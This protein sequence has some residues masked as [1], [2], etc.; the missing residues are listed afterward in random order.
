[1]LL[2]TV[3]QFQH[4]EVKDNYQHGQ[5]GGCLVISRLPLKNTHT[6]ANIL[7]SKIETLKLWKDSSAKFESV[8]KY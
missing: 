2:L 5:P 8:N 7:K 6:A 3:M 4:L 1:M